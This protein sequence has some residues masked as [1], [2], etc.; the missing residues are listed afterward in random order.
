M[1]LIEKS[2]NATEALHGSNAE[3][4]V[5]M[6]EYMLRCDIVAELMRYGAD[7]SSAN[8]QRVIDGIAPD[9]LAEELAKRT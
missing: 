9:V 7:T 8:V 3:F 6:A 4:R 2:K 1:G 5:K